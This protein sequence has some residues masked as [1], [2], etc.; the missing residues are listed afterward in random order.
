[1]DAHLSK[2]D[3]WRASCVLHPGAGD[4]EYTMRCDTGEG[5][6]RFCEIV[7]LPRDGKGG[8]DTGSLD[9]GFRGCE[10]GWPFLRTSSEK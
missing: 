9:C 2:S 8:V 4:V 10:V 7:G 6:M 5:K 3:S 1:M